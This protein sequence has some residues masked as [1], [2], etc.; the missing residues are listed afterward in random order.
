[1]ADQRPSAGNA[2]RVMPTKPRQMVEIIN[3]GECTEVKRVCQ[4][5]LRRGDGDHTPGQVQAICPPKS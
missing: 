5:I 3:G 1:M 2:L 4:R